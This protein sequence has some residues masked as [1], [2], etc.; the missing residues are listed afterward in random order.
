M[1]R[2][3]IPVAVAG[4]VLLMGGLAVAPYPSSAAPLIPSWSIQSTPNPAG[5][6][7][8]TLNGVSCTSATLCT[9]VGFDDSPSVGGVTLAERLTGTSWVIQPTPNPTGAASAQLSSV[10]CVSAN[11]CTAVGSY[12]TSGNIFSG[13]LVERWNGT[14]WKIQKSPN[15]TT[16]V[17]AGLLGV[18]CVST[19]ACTAVGS[20]DKSTYA[21]YPLAEKWNG[22]SWKVQ[23]VK[24]P[25][26]STYLSTMLPEPGLYSVSCTTATT[27]TAVGGNYTSK[28]LP[29]PLAEQLKGTSWS[30]QSTPVPAGAKSPPGLARSGLSSVSC[31]ST[32]ACTAVGGYNGSTSGTLAEVWN[33]STWKIQTT[34]DFPGS[35]LQELAGVWCTSATS[36]TGVGTYYVNGT[37]YSTLAEQFDGTSW[38]IAT[39]P[40]PAGEAPGLS[41][42]W[43]ASPI[44]CS[45]V[46]EGGG[47]A[48]GTLAETF[49]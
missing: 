10:S 23:S 32:T 17:R 43:C 25:V 15:P 37:G 26:G 31:T 3:A 35:S 27:C 48:W 36:C 12:A 34:P 2:H 7:F 42:V 5:S 33:G 6:Q 29:V 11:A 46:G 38:S 39:T 16:A 47:Y 1:N 41:A 20:Y 28:G 45:A 24:N 14:Q 40:N 44:S 21:Q 9:A 22:T 18:S 4:A 8:G 13:T 49:G 19:T 30:I